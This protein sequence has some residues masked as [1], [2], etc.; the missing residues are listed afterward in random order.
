M[1]HWKKILMIWLSQVCVLNQSFSRVFEVLV[2]F[3]EI[4]MIVKKSINFLCDLQKSNAAKT[5]ISVF[6]SIF[7]LVYLVD[8][9]DDEDN[10]FEQEDISITN[11]IQLY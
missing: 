8:N 11:I 4:A 6:F 2:S 3:L 5:S 7:F 9:S 1:E 10:F